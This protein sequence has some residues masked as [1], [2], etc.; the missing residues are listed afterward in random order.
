MFSNNH[1]LTAYWPAILL[2]LYGLLMSGQVKAWDFYD[3]KKDDIY[4]WGGTYT[5]FSN[6]ESYRGA[7]WL[8]GVEVVKPNDHVYGV[9]VFNNS[10]GQFSQYFFYG[11]VF[12][13]KNTNFHG[14]ITGGLIHGYKGEHR[15]NL[16]FNEL[17]GVAPVI[18]PGIGYQKNRWGIDL[19]LLATQGLL[20]GVGYQF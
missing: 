16:Y 17:L 3:D 19:Y 9:A 11:K 7:S 4:L 10:F 1:R 6:S 15:D 8:L 12:R 18:V 20:L 13:Y 2:L 14:K 5:H